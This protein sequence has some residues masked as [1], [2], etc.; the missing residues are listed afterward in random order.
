MTVGAIITPVWKD[1]RI[2]VIGP[3]IHRP[4][5]PPRPERFQPLS[6]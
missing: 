4:I 6:N 3:A 5:F 1:G 2:N